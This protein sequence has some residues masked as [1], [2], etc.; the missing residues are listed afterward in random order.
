MNRFRA[1]VLQRKEAPGYV[2]LCRGV[3]F[4]E[5]TAKPCDVLYLKADGIFEC[6]FF[7]G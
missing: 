2:Q 1:P 3:P 5:R 6:F 7:F 4:Q